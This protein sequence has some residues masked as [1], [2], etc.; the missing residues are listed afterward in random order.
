[1]IQKTVVFRTLLIFTAVL[2]GYAQTVSPD[3]Q[4]PDSITRPVTATL[5]ALYSRTIH[6]GDQD[7]F[8]ISAPRRGFLILVTAG[9]M[10]TCMELF[11][12]STQSPLA[13][14]DDGGDGGNSRIEYF[15]EPG[16][17]YIAMV[18]GYED[19]T[20]SYQFQ[21]SLE[22]VQADPT[23]PNQTRDQA[24]A[25]TLGSEVNAYFL[26]PADVDWYRLSIP[27]A[28]NVVI[29]TEGNMD[30]LLYLHD[31]AGELIA[32]D[33]D[34][35][36]GDNARIVASLPAGTVY[37]RVKAYEGQQG[38]YTLR[39]LLRQPVRP[40]RFENDDTIADAQDIQ[41]GSSQERTLSTTDDVDWVRLRI[42]RPGVYEIRTT[43][44][45]KKFDTYLD[46]YNGQAQVVESD[47]DGGGNYDALIRTTLAP[48]PYFIKVTNRNNELPDNNT[49]TLSV[50]PG[51]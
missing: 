13:E 17:T 34:S 12:G 10:D 48:G 25:I 35:G 19:E 21:A 9:D 50:T 22:P 29:Y 33:D 47:D 20:G 3:P 31:S 2:A 32:E 16:K 43:A 26:S 41:I 8:A 27:A 23:E 44:V 18:R 45:D 6:S 38:R 30:T 40:D 46:L 4:E 49:Y 5:D 11:D 36:S 37:I 7:W 51:R 1:M 42:T 24:A 39:T 28:G 15:T 14:D